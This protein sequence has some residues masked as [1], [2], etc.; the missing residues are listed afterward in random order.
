[1]N[2]LHRAAPI[3]IAS[4]A[5]W[6][7]MPFAPEAS[8]S[9]AAPI[10]IAAIAASEATLGTSR[11]MKVTNVVVPQMPAS[12][13]AIR[14][15]RGDGA[16]R[17]H[18]RRFRLD[19]RGAELHVHAIQRGLQARDVLVADA[20]AP[21]AAGEVRRA[22]RA[23]SLGDEAQ[24]AE[25]AI[26]ERA[27][28][29]GLLAQH[30]DVERCVGGRTLEPVAARIVERDVRARRRRRDDGG[31]V[32]RRL[33]HRRVRADGLDA[34]R[35]ARMR[36]RA[37]ELLREAARHERERV[38][39]RQPADHRVGVAAE[40]DGAEVALGLVRTVALLAARDEDEDGDEE[41]PVD[42]EGVAA[43]RRELQCGD[44]GQAHGEHESRDAALAQQRVGVVLVVR[45]LVG[46]D[47][48]RLV[49]VE[50]R[51]Q[52][53][54]HRDGAHVQRAER[55]GVHDLATG[56][57]VAM[58]RRMH[59]QPRAGALEHGAEARQQRGVRTAGVERRR[60]VQRE[61]D[62]RR[63]SG[64]RRGTPPTPRCRAR[65]PA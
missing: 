47:R 19:G 46:E 22:K 31:L 9:T 49:R 55:R 23:R 2:A 35:Q 48:R 43:T 30:A 11:A 42:H 32:A 21:R 8:E 41:E 60:L 16:R 50:I 39:L 64:A 28:A 25:L 44:R 5:N 26:G 45:D 27:V 53:V 37:L 62:A 38:D 14:S 17:G 20:H 33:D 4:A 12:I 29:R 58:Y 63:S 52:C 59:R 51:E 34:A 65:A 15:E 54:A 56:R 6:Y 18:P 3:T 61:P 7:G 36:G 57:A 13:V 10:A 40:V 1:M 24:L